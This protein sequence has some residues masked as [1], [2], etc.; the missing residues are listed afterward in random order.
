M[1]DLRRALHS[2][3][4]T[5]EAISVDAADAA[6]FDESYGAV[7][8]ES[9]AGSTPKAAE[10]TLRGALRE[11][12]VEIGGLNAHIQQLEEEW[13]S[14]IGEYMQR[15]AQLR[16]DA[17]Q[18]QRKSAKLERELAAARERI[19]SLE[20]G[21]EDAA[22][23]SDERLDHIVEAGTP[24]ASLAA[25]HGGFDLTTPTVRSTPGLSPASAMG[26]GLTSKDVILDA[27]ALL[28][29]GRDEIAAADVAEALEAESASAAQL[30][31][32][33]PASKP[34][35]ADPTPSSPAAAAPTR[36]PNATPRSPANATPRSPANATP[37]SPA[38]AT[39]VVES[40]ARLTL[41][42][43]AASLEEHA[44]APPKNAGGCCIVS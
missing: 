2:F 7:G 1:D 19:E 17:K 33:A 13:S 4:S 28:S 9:A 23:G 21:L 44:T 30:F 15:N 3:F 5:R 16:V 22:L 40:P 38:D 10:V 36:S 43:V 31:A 12:D 25:G 24:V 29:D 34:Q 42:D 27:D 37:R 18:A 11:A 6:V 39:P 41:D 20:Q 26:S 35:P 8:T 14:K 32:P